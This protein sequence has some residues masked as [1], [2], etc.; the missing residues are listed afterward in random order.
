VEKHRARDEGVRVKMSMSSSHPSTPRREIGDLI[1]HNNALSRA[2]RCLSDHSRFWAAGSH[3]GML[4]RE[5]R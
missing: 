4:F 3:L 1:A 2:R 5:D